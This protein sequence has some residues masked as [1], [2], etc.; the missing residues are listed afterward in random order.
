MFVRF[1]TGAPSRSLQEA[2][3]MRR[4][5]QITLGRVMAIVVL[6]ALV[7]ALIFQA[8]QA[9]ERE[10][11]YQSQIS[12]LRALVDPN[13]LEVLDQHRR[14]SYARRDVIIRFELAVLVNLQ[15]DSD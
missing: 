6:I 12:R 10:A 5:H 3:I 11:R 4:F 9:A 15:R 13:M 2:G 8:R 7:L 14:R 1:V